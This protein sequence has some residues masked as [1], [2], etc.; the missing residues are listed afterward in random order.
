MQNKFT[1]RSG[2][3]LLEL[4]VSLALLALIGAGLAGAFGLGTQVWT[5]S[6]ALGIHAQEI[7][8]RSQFRRF[9]SQ[10]LPPT[11]LTPFN[12]EFNGEA[13]QLTFVTLAETPSVQSA[14]ATRMT[15]QVRNSTLVLVTEFLDDEA[16][17]ISSLE[18]LLVAEAQEIRFDYFNADGEWVDAWSDPSTLPRLVRIRIAEGSIPAWPEFTVRLLLQ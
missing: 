3:S 17:V 18:D 15:L 2:L 7:A 16:G 8:L 10:A 11:R 5:R 13:N 14:A 12:A 6:Q 1:P 9:L 4:L